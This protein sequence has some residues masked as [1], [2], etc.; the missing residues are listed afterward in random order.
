MPGLL[1]TYGIRPG[2]GVGLFC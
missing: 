2:N 1:A